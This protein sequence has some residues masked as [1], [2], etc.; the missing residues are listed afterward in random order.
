MLPVPSTQECTSGAPSAI[1]LVLVTPD[2]QRTMRT[3]HGSSR[4]LQSASQLPTGWAEGCQLLH[5]SGYCLAR[6]QLV[7]EV[8]TLAKAAGA[9]VS[10]DLASFEVGMEAGRT[11]WGRVCMWAEGIRCEV[12]SLPAPRRACVHCV[13][14]WV[15]R[16]V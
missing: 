11:G 16:S 6:P 1:C 2:G 4:G 13:G 7:R 14:R 12:Q 10:I 5:C 3:C 15:M 8:M 9:L